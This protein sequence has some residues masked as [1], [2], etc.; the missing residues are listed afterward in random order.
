MVA[1]ERDDV[2]SKPPTR[3]G[4]SDVGSHRP[5]HMMIPLVT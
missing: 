2:L 1:V 4:A 5:V 3:D